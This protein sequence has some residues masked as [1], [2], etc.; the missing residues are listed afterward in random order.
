MKNKSN[1]KNTATIGFI[2]FGNMA[3]AIAAGLLKNKLVRSDAILAFEPN[4][5]RLTEIQKKYKIT[6]TKNL[7]ELCYKARVIV[8][9]VK[10]QNINEVLPELMTVYQN[11][12]IITIVTGIRIK[13]YKKY[14]GSQAKII[15]VIPNTP[16]LIGLGAAAYFAD[17]ACTWSDKK[18]CEDFFNSI[19]RIWPLKHEPQLDA[20]TAISGSGPAFV[21]QYAEAIINAAHKTGLPLKLAKDLVLQTLLGATQMML[22][23]SLS[24]DEL[25][26]KVTSRG[27]TTLAGLKVLKKKGFAKILEACMVRAAQRAKELSQ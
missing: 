3:E 19:G 5:K 26:Q 14:L 23:S 2:G 15:R 10:P 11:Q 27:G 17:P 4:T 13:H 21:Y 25:T 22:Q 24:P 8:I 7:T 18:L 1:K 12:L 6:P 20:V 9:A 16:A